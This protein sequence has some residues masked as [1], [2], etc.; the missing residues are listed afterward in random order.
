MR[1]AL[2]A[3]AGT[4]AAVV[5]ILQ[6][7]SAGTF[8]AGGGQLLPAA[9]SSAATSTTTPP[10]G[11]SSTSASSGTSPATTPP[12]TTPPTTAAPAT[13]AG[14]NGQ[15]TGSDVSF[16]YGEI[17]VRLTYRDGKITSV[18]FPIDTAPDPRSEFINSQALP[19]LTQELLRAQSLNIDG[20]SGAT[21]TSNAFAQTVQAA[22][23]KA[24]K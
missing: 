5:A 15:F 21:F 20:V 7:K 10:A 14:P 18:N 24:G 3:T 8:K 19:I 23:S 9:G 1:R 13:S 22:L 12:T 4:V 16:I 11:S 17:E 2:I 6:Y